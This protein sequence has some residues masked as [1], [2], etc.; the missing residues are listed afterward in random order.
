LKSRPSVQPRL[1]ISERKHEGLA[2][3][4][5]RTAKKAYLRGRCALCPCTKRRNDQAPGAAQPEKLATPHALLPNPPAMT[6]SSLP[7]CRQEALPNPFSRPHSGANLLALRGTNA[8]TESSS[9][10]EKTHG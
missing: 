2:H 6:R 10:R 4:G 8:A 9:K 3:R 7:Y 1:R 5:G